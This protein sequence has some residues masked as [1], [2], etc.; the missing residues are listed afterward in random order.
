MNDVV[1]E[2]SQTVA[3]GQLRAF[4][5]RIERLEEEKKSISEDIKDVYAEMK[6]Q[7]FDTKAVRTIV[8]LRKKDQA[9]RQEEEAILDLYKA[10]L[11]MV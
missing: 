5:E 6:A 10:A 9:E 4:V 3:A 2:T 11:G 8:R 1:N 7:G